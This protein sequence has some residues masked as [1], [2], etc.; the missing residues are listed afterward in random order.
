MAG[1]FPSK[2]SNK[3]LEIKI[4]ELKL[5][6]IEIIKAGDSESYVVGASWSSVRDSETGAEFKKSVENEIRI[7]IGDDVSCRTIKEAW[8]DC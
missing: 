7:L 8:Q 5:S 4:E 2:F 6:R 3:E 1:Y